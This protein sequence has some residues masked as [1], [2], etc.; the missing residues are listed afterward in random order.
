LHKLSIAFLFSFYT[1]QLI[2]SVHQFYKVIIE[3]L[4]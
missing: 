2:P 1:L 4:L 3:S